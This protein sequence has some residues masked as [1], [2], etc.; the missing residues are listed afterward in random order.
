MDCNADSLL[1]FDLFARKPELRLPTGKRHY[2]TC[3][4]CLCSILYLA[5]IVVLP[6]FYF[7]DFWDEDYRRYTVSK[8][9]IR[10]AVS[11]TE[12][13][14]S[15]KLAFALIDNANPTSKLQ[16]EIGSFKAYLRTWDLSDSNLAVA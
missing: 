5:A 1:F 15:M 6:V 4:G 16:P 3:I 14:D 12:S 8:T 11:M 13:Y 10:D 9:E 2:S 7:R